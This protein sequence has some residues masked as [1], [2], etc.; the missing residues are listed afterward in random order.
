M[1]K[2]LR[3]A[4]SEQES[5]GAVYEKLENRAAEVWRIIKE[6]YHSRYVAGDHDGIQPGTRHLFHPVE[7]RHMPSQACQPGITVLRALRR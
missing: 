2:I 7:V 6:R 4:Q 5:R 1:G 3:N